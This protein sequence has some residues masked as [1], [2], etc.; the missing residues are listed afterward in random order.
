M[1]AK[2]F[3]GIYAFL[4]IWLVFIS[5][6]SRPEQ[7]QEHKFITVVDDLG[8][9]IQIPQQPQRIMALAPSATE[10]LYAVADEKNIVGRTQNCDY[11]AQVKNKPVVNNYPMDYEQII[12]LKPDLVFTVE[13]I[14]SAEEAAKLQE[15]NIPVYFQRFIKV[16]DIF[17]GL[18][19][20]GKLLHREERAKEVVDSLQS[21]LA[22][23]KVDSVTGPKPRVL[24]I[25]Y[26]DPIYVYGQNTIFTDKL[27]L[28]NAE[29]AVTE[30]FPQPYPALTR[31]YILKLNP[32]VIIGGSFEKMDATFFKMYPEL[33]KIKAYQQKKIFAAT[34]DLMAR[35]GPRVIASIQ[36]LKDFIW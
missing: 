27:K 11:P 33:K 4:I 14:T 9:E 29:N 2:R 28:I 5:C 16:Q 18:Q 3:F 22:Q 12:L 7:K 21:V 17:D 32:D 19:D 24:A 36:E 6:N 15:L 31:E 1:S 10:M 35:P 34:D 26:P 30:I 25:T 20:L 23:I 8:R 13:G